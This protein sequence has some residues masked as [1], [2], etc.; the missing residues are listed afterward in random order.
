MRKH[1]LNAILL[2]CIAIVLFWQV[3][4]M[5]HVLRWDAVNCFLTWRHNVSEMIRSQHLPLWS[6]WQHLGFPLH[7]DPETGAWYPI[8]WIISAFR[9]YDFYALSFEWILHIFIGGY[10]MYRLITGRGIRT[11]IALIAAVSFMGCGVFVSNAQN[12]IY[13]IGLAWFP[14]VS[15]YLTMLWRYGSGKYLAWTAICSAMMLTGSYPGISIIGFY[16]MAAA[17]AFY[18]FNHGLIRKKAELKSWLLSNVLAG[19]LIFLLTA[20]HLLSV[21]EYIPHVTRTE[22]LS[23]ERLMENPFPPKAWV[24]LLTP[25]SVG[26]D[27]YTDHSTGEETRFQW[28]SDFSMLNMYGGLLMAALLLAWLM[29]KGK[30]RTEWFLFGGF[31]VLMMLAMG[32]VFPL[33]WWSRNLPG[34]D[35][36]RHPSIFR[37]HALFVW[38]VLG[39]LTMERW[40]QQTS[41]VPL[42]TASLVV[43]SGILL[44]LL[45]HLPDSVNNTWQRVLKDITEYPEVSGVSVSERI[46]THA[47]IQLVLLSLIML[48][49]RK[50]KTSWLVPLVALD[51]F[52]AVQLNIHATVVYPMKTSNAQREMVSAVQGR[53]PYAGENLIGFHSDS[54][55][56]RISGLVCNHHIILQQPAWDGYNSFILAGYRNLEHSGLYPACFNHPLV[57]ATDSN[58]VANNIDISSNSI[59]CTVSGTGNLILQQNFHPNWSCRI[60]EQEVPIQMVNHTMMQVQVT[61]DGN[62]KFTYKSRAASAGVIFMVGG[63]LVSLILIFGFPGHNNRRLIPSWIKRKMRS[64]GTRIG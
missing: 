55:D 38:I 16:C 12:F 40:L 19:A 31:V 8:I 23:R 34:L 5:Q 13:L 52:I 33:R 14:W 45:T 62:V 4:A 6:P 25:Y 30:T 51:M 53:K 2:A 35:M 64:S 27:H 9:S 59:S 46:F 39:A 54:C 56:L 18:F 58:L 26:T 10:G 48:A 3:G 37:F 17:A 42:R 63:I 20:P 22:G 49:V 47:W 1:Y 60:N 41:K 7:A 21:G 36:F 43:I 24:S 61:E 50:S 44:L 57:Y 15:H 28:G 32:D 29:S 11:S